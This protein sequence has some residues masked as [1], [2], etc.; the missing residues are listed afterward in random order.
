M[1]AY[2]KPWDYNVY[3]CK[4]CLYS[5]GRRTGCVYPK[6]CC[7]PIPQKPKMRFG[8]EIHY[9][10]PE[11]QTVTKSDC[12]N[13][14]YGRDSPC[15]GWCTKEVMKAVGLP[16]ERSLTADFLKSL[17]AVFLAEAQHS[18]AHPVSLYFQLAAGENALNDLAGVRP[19]GHCPVGEISPVPFGN[20]SVILGKMAQ[21]GRPLAPAGCSRPFTD[22]V[23]LFGENLH[24]SC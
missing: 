18:L 3:S 11:K 24:C 14:P 19:N 13:C 6:G 2:G 12:D 15:I 20:L 10:S 1:R 4:Y 22:E 17:L 5:K 23:S 9:P 7:C 8:T 16:R 21:I